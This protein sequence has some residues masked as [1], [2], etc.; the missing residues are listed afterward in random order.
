MNITI[1]ILEA[2]SS[3]AHNKLVNYYKTYNSDKSE[4][5]IEN[6]IIV[7]DGDCGLHYT[8]EAQDIFND[9]YDYYFDILNEAR[10]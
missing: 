5:E 8:E 9:Y 2:S 10:I 1:N 3:L 4:G 6:M 7:E